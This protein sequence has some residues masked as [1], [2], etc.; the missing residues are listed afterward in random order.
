MYRYDFVI[1]PYSFY[2]LGLP[3][4]GFVMFQKLL[5]LYSFWGPITL[6]N[7]STLPTIVLGSQ[8]GVFGFGDYMR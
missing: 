4:L 7:L 8:Q 2:L 3:E 5:R 6:S 1:L